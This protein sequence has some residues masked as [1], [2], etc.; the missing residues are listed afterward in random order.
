MHRKIRL[1]IWG[2]SGHALV[3]ADIVQLMGFE[4][5]GFL[6]DFIPC[7]EH[8]MIRGLPH[9]GGKKNLSLLSESVTNK[10]VLAFGHCN[11]RLK[12]STIA[13]KAGFD[14]VAVIHPQAVIA[15]DVSVG[16]G[17]V[18]VAG[19]VINASTK[20]GENVI[21]NTCA[22]V[23]HECVIEDGAHI[24][25]GARLGG[26]VIVQR[27]AWVGIGATVKDRVTIG[28]N[29]IVG[30]GAVVLNDVPRDKVVFGSPA[31]VVRL[32]KADEN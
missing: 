19:A 27:A 11:A 13:R 22:S 28:A 31:R 16:D 2:T 1:I 32:V 14:L 9:L 5:V 23:D 10:L 30:A 24:G 4:I 20:I 17:S 26:R 7:S 25:P 15:S 29:S 8:R 21:I 3:V 6:D 18:I 12:L